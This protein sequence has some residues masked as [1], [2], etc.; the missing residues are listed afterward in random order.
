[1][2]CVP[3]P[4]TVLAAV[5]APVLLL[6]LSGC[7]GDAAEPV[8]AEPERSVAE[9]APVEPSMSEAAEA[10]EEA[11][12]SQ[13]PEP[14]GPGEGT[15]D[16]KTLVPA[17]MAAMAD[18]Q[19]SHF[20]MTTAGGGA[21]VEAEGEMAYRGKTQDMA[22]TMSGATLGAESMEIRSV[23][24]VV[25]LSMPPMTPKGKFVEIRPGDTSSPFAGMMD[26]M[27]VDPRDSVKA[28]DAGLRKV[29]YLGEES[30]HGED[31]ERYRLSVDFA[32]VAKAQGMPRMAGMPK[33]VEYDM[34]LDGQALLRRME[35]DLMQVS[36]VMEMS[37]WGEPVSIKAPAR[38][39]IVAAPG[40]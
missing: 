3:R 15:W 28:F 39:D 27:Q 14:T 12:V 6:A 11:L 20:T 4:R 5:A 36:M 32:A 24:R 10:A 18:Q 31:L 40:Q 33:T 29:T 35:F 25:Y 17:M 21:D 1:M 19:T 23:D 30:V 37:E 22:M 38:K 16:E 8:A 9:T 2:R 34:W 7:G 13:T 26:Q